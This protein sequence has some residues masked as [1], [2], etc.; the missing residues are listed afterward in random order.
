MKCQ[1]QQRKQDSSCVCVFRQH[2]S[3]PLNSQTCKLVPNR[4]YE[5]RQ[6]HSSDTANNVQAIRRHSAPVVKDDDDALRGCRLK[7]CGNFVSNS[8]RAA[9]ALTPPASCGLYQFSMSCVYFLS[10]PLSAQLA[11]MSLLVPTREW[12]ERVARERPLDL[13]MQFVQSTSRCLQNV[14]PA[15]ARRYSNWTQW[16]EL[17]RN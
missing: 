11:R 3:C 5:R 17:R 1:Q 12:S 7:Y 13:I 6:Q 8:P 10:A 4:A 15:I 14:A 16:A 9:P 2:F